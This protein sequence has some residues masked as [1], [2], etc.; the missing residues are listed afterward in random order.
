MTGAV[1]CTPDHGVGPGGR[2]A[3]PLS[4]G[5]AMVQLSAQTHIRNDAIRA[6]MDRL[7]AEHSAA[8]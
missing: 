1:A 4:K 3:S 6:V 5:L 2:I 8:R 7:R